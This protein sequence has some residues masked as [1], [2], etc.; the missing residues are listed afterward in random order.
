MVTLA[1]SATQNVVGLARLEP[2]RR[3]DSPNQPS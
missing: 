3:F 2:R 1:M